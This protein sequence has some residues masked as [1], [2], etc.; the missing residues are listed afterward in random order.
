MQGK[1]IQHDRLNQKVHII[2]R[3]CGGCFNRT[4]FTEIAYL[5]TASCERT[6]RVIDQEE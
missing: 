1:I 6:I 3:R 5:V 4:A 2:G